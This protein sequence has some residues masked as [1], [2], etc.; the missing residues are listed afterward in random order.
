MQK[1]GVIGWLALTICMATAAFAEPLP[2][3]Y[4]ERFGGMYALD[5]DD[6]QS[7][8]LTVLADRLILANSEGEWVGE[9]AMSN[10]S[11]FGRSLPPEGYQVALIGGDSPS[12]F[13]T[14]VVFRDEKGIF[15]LLEDRPPASVIAGA[16]SDGA[17]RYRKCER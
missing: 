9:Q 1:T 7:E 11:Y 15:I 13:L 6:A 8:R 3:V 14:F 10:A 16:N 17:A 5:C 4:V 2:E 12:T